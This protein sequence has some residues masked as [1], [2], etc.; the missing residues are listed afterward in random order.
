MNE[1]EVKLLVNTYSEDPTDWIIDAVA[2]NLDKDEEL[3]S[4]TVIRYE[5]ES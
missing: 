1:F 5:Q 3:V 2:D 4:I